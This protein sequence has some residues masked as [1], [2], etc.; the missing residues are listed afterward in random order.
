MN[1]SEAAQ[2][3]D[4]YLDGELNGSLRLEFDAHRLRCTACQQ[5]LAMM[6]ACEHILASETRGPKFSPNFT[7]NVMNEIR[8]NGFKTGRKPRRRMIY[9]AAGVMQAAAVI[10]FAFLWVHYRSAPAPV[11]PP[12]SDRGFTTKVGRAIDNKDPIELTKL[13]TARKAQI[14][15]ALTNVSNDARAVAGLLPSIFNLGDAAQ[16][17]PS[18]LLEYFLPSSAADDESPNSLEATPQPNASGTFSL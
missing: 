9:I 15:S 12:G 4:A 3:F 16:A 11:L 1:C 17:A 7:N 10:V 18:S 8:L 5:K 14:Q 13:M 6:E 2:F